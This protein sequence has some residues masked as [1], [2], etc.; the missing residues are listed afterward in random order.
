MRKEG[1]TS[2]ESGKFA[3]AAQTYSAALKA[4][5]K[6]ARETRWYAELLSNRSAAYA[7]LER[8]DVALNDADKCAKLAPDWPKVRL[9]LGLG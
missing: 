5:P 7:K 6:A 8:Y 4:T 3:H 9:G 1:N 2:F